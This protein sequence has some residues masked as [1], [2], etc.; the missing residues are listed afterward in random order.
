MGKNQLEILYTAAMAQANKSTMLHR[1]GAVIVGKNGEILGQGFNHY[2]SFYSHQF[3]MHAEIAAIQ[4][5]KKKKRGFIQPEDL[6]MIVVRV[7]GKEG[8]YT[9]LS[10]PCCNCK[11]EIQ[12]IGIK[13]V[14]YS[15]S[16]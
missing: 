8:S 4:N 15:V 1:H 2:T 3:S 7:A 6:T 14:F 11:R 9:M 16:D 10:K 13:R 5:M 12:K